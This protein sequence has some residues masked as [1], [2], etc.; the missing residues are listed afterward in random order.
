MVKFF[1]IF[2]VSVI[3]WHGLQI[4]V[5]EIFHYETYPM[6]RFFK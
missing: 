4:K 6:K 3:L 1:V 2:I 5:G